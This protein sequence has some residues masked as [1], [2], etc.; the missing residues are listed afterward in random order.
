MER[1]D[2]I[3]LGIIETYGTNNPY[4]ILEEMGINII[5]VDKEHN[6]LLKKNSIFIDTLNIIFLRNDLTDH[7]KLFYLRH[8]LG[9]VLLHLD[10]YNMAIP[11][12][13]KHEKE[14]DYFALGLSQYEF[15]KTAMDQMTI[16]QIACCLE[17]PL[18][19]LTQIVNV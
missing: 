18:R 12:E 4:E 3:V 11:N 17:V 10:Q 2:E 15:D 16:E 5:E 19:A 14:A 9:H 6:I 8:E 13:L 7:Y 1:I